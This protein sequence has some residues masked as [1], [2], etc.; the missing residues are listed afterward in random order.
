MKNLFFA[1]LLVLPSSFLFPTRAMAPQP[2]LI[3]SGLRLD[4]RAEKLEEF[5]NH[6]KCPLPNYAQNYIDDADQNKIPWELLPAISVQESTCGKHQLSNNWWGWASA[7]S[8]FTDVTA[9]IQ[10][11]SGQLVAGHFYAG[12]STYQKLR[13]YNPDPA[14]ATK[15]INLMSQIDNE[16]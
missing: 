15:I 7:R 2:G 10:Y 11:V 6:Y 14:Y 5:F 1:L 16:K 13:R 9:G 8:G 4:T 12:L 3:S